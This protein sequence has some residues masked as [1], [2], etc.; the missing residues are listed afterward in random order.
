MTSFT[1]HI[2]RRT[3]TPDFPVQNAMRRF[4][5]L[6]GV[7][8][9]LQD[10]NGVQCLGEASPLP[11]YSPDTL[12]HT[13]QVLSTAVALLNKQCRTDHMESLESI[14]AASATIP[15]TAPAARFA[16][17][18]ALLDRLATLRNVPIW[19]LFVS[20][21]KPVAINGLLNCDAGPDNIEQLF[22]QGVR[23]F[24]LKV[25]RPG[26]HADELRLLSFLRAGYG[27]NVEIRLDA[28]GGLSPEKMN[29]QMRDYS[30]FTPT[31]IEEPTPYPS[32]PDAPMWPI[33]AAADE[34]LISSEN[35]ALLLEDSRYTVWVLKPTLLG[36]WFAVRRL[37][38][39]A[40]GA[41]KRIIVTH[42]FESLPAFLAHIHL[43]ISL[44]VTDACGLYPHAGLGP[45]RNHTACKLTNGQLA[46]PTAV[47]LGVSSREL[48]SDCA[49]EQV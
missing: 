4:P 45:F 35:R 26:R 43:T 21:A 27:D 6:Q 40:R 1:W 34:S 49:G 2:R 24:K 32:A 20:D 16:L 14:E 12:D 29:S 28:N 48:E 31:F 11:G 41:G 36:G 47:G 9:Y 8:L 18:T 17:E 7:Y 23:V 39:L 30:E 22:H 5:S 44:G 3:R 19:Q 15:H 13:E 46:V 33:A 37:A 42:I 38:A 25:G 10:E